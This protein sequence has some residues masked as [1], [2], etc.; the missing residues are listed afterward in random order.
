MNWGWIL[1]PFRH[2][3]RPCCRHEM[4]VNHQNGAVRR[5]KHRLKIDAIEDG[6][7]IHCGTLKH[8]ENNWAARKTMQK[9]PES[10]QRASKMTS[11][12]TQGDPGTPK[13]SP[14][15]NRMNWG[16]I[17][18]PFRHP[19]WPCFRD[20]MRVKFGK[21]TTEKSTS[22]LIVKRCQKW[23]QHDQKYHQNWRQKGLEMSCKAKLLNYVFLQRV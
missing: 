17:L 21:N 9:G 1:D 22:G 14:W 7:W 19:P 8:I 15:S 18:D 13:G 2:P 16:W 11:K 4:R 5:P 3:P 20:E 10:R 12:S 6:F 23:C